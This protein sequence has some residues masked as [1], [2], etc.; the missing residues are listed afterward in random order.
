MGAADYKY[1]AFRCA[2]GER[3][4]VHFLRAGFVG[5]QCNQK[6]AGHNLGL[7]VNH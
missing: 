6:H 1:E 7:P 2:D 5:K 3:K 4:L